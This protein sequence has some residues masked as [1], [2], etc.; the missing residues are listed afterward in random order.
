MS[1]IL[2]KV[3]KVFQKIV[4]SKIFKIVAIAAA[5]YF[6]AGIAAGAMGSVFAASLPGIS[7]AASAL[8]LG[9]VGAFGAAALQGAGVVGGAIAAE[10]GSVGLGATSAVGAEMGTAGAAL[11]EAGLGAA[12][13]GAG[14]A[15]AGGALATGTTADLVGGVAEGGLQLT[16]GITGTTGTAADAAA[17][18][19]A[20]SGAGAWMNG[21]A[22]YSGDAAGVM[23]PMT[24][25]AADSASIFGKLGDGAKGVIKFF[26]D[27]PTVAKAAMTFGSDALKAGVGMYAQK[28][29]QEAADERAAQTRDRMAAPIIA[30]KV[31]YTKYNKGVVNAVV[32]GT[33][34][35]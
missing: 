6:T 4:K 9:E 32:N 16:S 27:N 28:S 7:T 8:G 20:E 11:G 2:K 19:A 18:N 17:A 34:G 33:D 30:N 31:D 21:A 3:G 15:A 14:E 22:G 1:G 12:G 25:T 24:K 10:A 23:S 29:Q 26:G 13:V 5:V 35:G